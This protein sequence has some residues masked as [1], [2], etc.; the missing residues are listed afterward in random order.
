V[1][2][3]P[4]PPERLRTG[5]CRG[6]PAR[7]RRPTRMAASVVSARRWFGRDRESRSIHRDTST[8]WSYPG[9]V[10][11]H[12]WGFPPKSPLL[13]RLFGM[14]TCILCEKQPCI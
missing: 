9:S 5:F 3:D 13:S 7:W 11:S 1:F 8:Q 12:Y 4:A 10:R 14:G 2:D 6:R